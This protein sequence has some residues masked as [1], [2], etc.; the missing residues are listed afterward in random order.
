MRK[1]NR[2]EDTAILSPV[3]CLFRLHKHPPARPVV[4]Q[5]RAVSPDT[6]SGAHTALMTA[7][8]SRDSRL[9][10]VNGFPL[11]A[12]SSF[13]LLPI[14]RFS[15]YHCLSCLIFFHAFFTSADFSLALF[16]FIAEDSCCPRTVRGFYYTKN[17]PVLP[18]EEKD[19]FC[20]NRVPL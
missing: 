11:R 15:V 7:C 8:Q 1:R 19:C 12:A 2:G 13:T 20:G 9:L 4:F 18:G 14:S 17:P 5:L 10:P 16:P 3:C 6:A